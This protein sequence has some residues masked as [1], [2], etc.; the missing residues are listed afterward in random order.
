MRAVRGDLV[1]TIA[2]IFYLFISPSLI[3]GVNISHRPPPIAYAPPPPIE[4]LN[5]ALW[6]HPNWEVMSRNVWTYV[7]LQVLGE[8]CWLGT[9]PSVLLGV[10]SRYIFPSELPKCLK[11]L[12]K[13]LFMLCCFFYVFFSNSPLGASVKS[14]Q[15][16]LSRNFNLWKP[17][18]N[19]IRFVPT[20]ISQNNQRRRYMYLFFC[21]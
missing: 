2:C 1:Y 3:E 11:W 17:L 14:S 4:G 15:K 13:A 10:R 9:L 5:F 16:L 8:L 6:P 7:R 21:F 20:K 12:Q 19:Y 18:S